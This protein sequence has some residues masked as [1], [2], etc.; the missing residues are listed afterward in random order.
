MKM[1]KALSATFLPMAMLALA[2]TVA[3]AGVFKVT[4]FVIVHPKKD[5]HVLVVKPVV[6]TA[7]AVK[8]VVY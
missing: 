7:K 5:A 1:L 8:A 4:K 6:F 2:T 3:Q